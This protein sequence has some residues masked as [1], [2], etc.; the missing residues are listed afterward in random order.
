SM[1]PPPDV[2]DLHQRL[3]AVFFSVR[4]DVAD[5][6]AAADAAKDRVYR[7]ALKR[8]TE[9]SNRLA[10]IGRQFGARGYERLGVQ[11]ST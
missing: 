8:V 3:L 2:K 6:V 4:Q 7:A 11:V 5:A 10:P 9:D 1:T